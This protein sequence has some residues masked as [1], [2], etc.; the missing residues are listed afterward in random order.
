M[1]IS[2]SAASLPTDDPRAVLDALVRDRGEDYA[3]LSRMIGRNAAYIQQ[4]IKRGTPRRLG[5]RERALLA[6]YFRIDEARLGAPPRSDRP[7]VTADGMR[8]VPRFDVGASAGPGG[9]V[10]DDRAEDQ[11]S[12]GER[13]LRRMSKTPDQL[14]IIR[15]EGDS[16]MP[17]LTHGDDIMVDHGDAGERLRDGVYVLR[18]DGVLLVKRLARGMGA[19]R[20]EV[21]IISDN[22][23]LYPG[24][25][26]PLAELDIVGRVVWVGR[27]L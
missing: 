6:R 4:F 2:S 11:F 1:K 7:A 16:M 23:D 22:R 27:R 18:R 13:M 26:A 3:A 8:N 10:D 12:F 20:G 14:S 25:E 24:I 21:S 19:G 5:E 15:V 17:T 9:L